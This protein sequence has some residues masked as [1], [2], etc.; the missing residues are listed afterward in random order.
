MNNCGVDS[1]S[2]RLLAG[3]SPQ[4]RIVL[5]PRNRLGEYATIA[6]LMSET[7]Q[8]FEVHA[9]IMTRTSQYCGNDDPIRSVP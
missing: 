4:T 8:L 7:V 5:W 9:T 6:E 2:F 3:I 1:P